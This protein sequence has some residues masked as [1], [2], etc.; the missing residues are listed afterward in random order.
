MRKAV[1][2]VWRR[3]LRI[4]LKPHAKDLCKKRRKRSQ[5]EEQET[6][7]LGLEIEELL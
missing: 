5:V 3:L 4:G 7:E 6:R 1:T 2:T